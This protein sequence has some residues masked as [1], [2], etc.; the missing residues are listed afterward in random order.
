MAEFMA[1]EVAALLADANAA[2]E[3]GQAALDLGRPDLATYF[4]R[5]AKSLHREAADMLREGGAQ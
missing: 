5:L 2:R 4:V 3:A 1:T